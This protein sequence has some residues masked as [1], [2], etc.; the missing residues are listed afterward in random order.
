V[1]NRAILVAFCLCLATSIQAADRLGELRLSSTP[2]SLLQGRLSVHVP[3]Q[4]VPAPI[5]EGVMGAPEAST[6]M[7]RIDVNAG[8][9]KMVLLAEELFARAGRQFEEGV[10]QKATLLPAKV[11]I[12]SWPLPEPLRGYACIPVSPDKDKEANLVLGLYVAQADGTVEELAFFVN[13]AGAVNFSE[14]LELARSIA[15]SVT[16]GKRRLEISAGER[17]LRGYASDL[18]ITVPEGF[19]ATEQQGTDFLVHHLRKITEFT[20]PP[21]DIGIYMGDAPSQNGESAKENGTGILLGQTA[22]WYEEEVDLDGRKG[23]FDRALI[24]IGSW[25]STG[26]PPTYVDVFL[27]AGDATGIQKLKKVAATLRFLNPDNPTH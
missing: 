15:R 1:R 11:K 4:A 16:P 20:D 3:A 19:V 7:T 5:Q 6:E 22:H 14:A 24:R 17:I 2:T 27:Q 13:Q 26:N 23:L 12:E 18:V 21:E 9:Q 25:P 8:S 10:K